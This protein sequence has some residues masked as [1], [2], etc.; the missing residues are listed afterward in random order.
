MDPSGDI[1][2]AAFKGLCSPTHP[3]PSCKCIT[4]VW[5]NC[6][7]GVTA[8]G[9]KP[10]R[11]QWQKNG[12]DIPDAAGIS[13]T[14]PASPWRIQAAYSDV[15]FRILRDSGVQSAILTV[16]GINV[17]KNGDFES[18][19][20]PWVFYSDAGGQFTECIARVSEWQVCGD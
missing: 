5:P 3:R 7:F 16:T 9:S 19:G 6:T 20:S 8:T 4:L 17:V 10:I 14:T 13:Y 15:L 1:R 12:V 2:G 18:G 11:Y